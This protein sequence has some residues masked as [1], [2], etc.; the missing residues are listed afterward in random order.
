MGF[1]G[2]HVLYTLDAF[3]LALY[4]LF[5]GCALLK[6]TCKQFPPK[7]GRALV[8]FIY[9]GNMQE[10]LLEEQPAAFLAMGEMFDL[11]ELKDLAEKELLIQLDKDNMLAMISL[12]EL[13]GADKIFEAALKLT[14]V[15]MSWLRTQVEDRI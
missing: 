5:H 1:T 6:Y 3:I 4:L 8:Q 15:N 12:G 11:Q 13:F 7:V 10:G 14:K 9:T 2:A